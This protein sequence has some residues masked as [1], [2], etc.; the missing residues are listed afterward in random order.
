ML[1]R[2]RLELPGDDYPSYRAVLVND[3]GEELWSGSKL[4]AETESGHVFVVVALTP[5]R[6]PRGDYQVKLSGLTTAGDSETAGSYP[7]RVSREALNV[8]GFSEHCS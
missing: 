1:V 4:K 2:L 6:L 3:A 8:I 5:D 7:F